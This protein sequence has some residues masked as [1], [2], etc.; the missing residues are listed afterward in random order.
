MP[1]RLLAMASQHQ[2]AAYE[3]QLPA[4]LTLCAIQEALDAPGCQWRWEVLGEVTPHGA[5]KVPSLWQ[6]ALGLL[7]IQHKGTVCYFIAPSKVW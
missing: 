7:L 6:L 3:M 4:D 2:A 5:D 1:F